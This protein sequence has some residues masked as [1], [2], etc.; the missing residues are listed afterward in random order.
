MR[1]RAPRT[2]SVLWAQAL[3]TRIE[4]LPILPWPH[5]SHHPLQ[6][7]A[8]FTRIEYLLPNLIVG[9]LTR[10]AVQVIAS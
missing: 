3:V 5:P 2:G 6:V 7:L 8:L 1:A 10:E 4:Y 9:S